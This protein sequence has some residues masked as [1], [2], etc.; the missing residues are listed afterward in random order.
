MRLNS[1]T[2]KVADRPPARRTNCRSIS[3]TMAIAPATVT[4]TECASLDSDPMSDHRSDRAR[5]PRLLPFVGQLLVLVFLLTASSAQAETVHTVA[6]VASVDQVLTNIR[7]WIMGILA[8]LATVFLSIAFVRRMT[9]AGD[10][11]EIEKAKTAFRS[12]CWGYLGALLTPLV[13]EVLKGFVEA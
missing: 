5:R 11:G 13:I 7:N 1:L 2:A 3:P 9:G 6:L 8:A 4:G 12:A 10:P